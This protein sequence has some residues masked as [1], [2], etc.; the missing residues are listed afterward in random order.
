M[1][2]EFPLEAFA[3][4]KQDYLSRRYSAFIYSLTEN[5]PKRFVNGKPPTLAIENAYTS[6]D[7]LS[8]SGSSQTSYFLISCTVAML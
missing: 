7:T 6:N 5:F 1:E 3:P 8:L 4:G 2:Y